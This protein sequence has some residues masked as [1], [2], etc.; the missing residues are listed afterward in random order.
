M[1]N[2]PLFSFCATS[3]VEIGSRINIT[4]KKDQFMVTFT[5]DAS[6]EYRGFSLRAVFKISDP[7]F[8]W[9]IKRIHKYRSENLKRYE[10]ASQITILTDSSGSAKVQG[11]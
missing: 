7:R 4:P 1:N 5:S 2:A 8:D 11:C 9:W 6:N 10:A 3:D